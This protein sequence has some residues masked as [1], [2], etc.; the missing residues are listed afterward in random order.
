MALTSRKAA[1]VA[2]ASSPDFIPPLQT[3][4][5]TA[6]CSQLRALQCYD[7]R[8]TYSDTLLERQIHSTMP[9]AVP[10][11]TSSGLSKELSEPLPEPQPF[12][13]MPGVRTVA[14]DLGNQ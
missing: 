10:K 8:D 3:P 9:T 1:R 2:E 4:Q 7:L 12:E 6:A 13:G 11:V 14:G 5:T